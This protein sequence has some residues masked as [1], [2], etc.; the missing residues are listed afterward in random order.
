MVIS[1]YRDLLDDLSR[2]YDN[3][4]E[5]KLSS[6][7]IIINIIKYFII[8]KGYRAICIYRISRELY[9]GNKKFLL[10]SVRLLN[11]LINNIEISYKAPIGPGLMIPHA[12]C[13]VIG[14]VSSIG[15]NVTIQQGVTIGAN[16]EKEIN[17]RKYPVIGSRVLIGAGA[18]II[19]PISI[20]DNSIIGANAVVV[21]DI[22]KNS[23]AVGVPA[24]VINTIEDNDPKFLYIINSFIS[25]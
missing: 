19:G 24:R 11:L 6:L 14:G 25:L 13:I 4:N 9:I 23:I 21:S 5:L 3:K 15:K 10:F 20:G 8:F 17:G 22:P 12:Q 18:K 7:I 16:I 2:I 1:M